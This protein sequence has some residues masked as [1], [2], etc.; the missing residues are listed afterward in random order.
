VTNQQNRGRR[1]LLLMALFFL[2]PLALAF[3]I[4]YGFD[5]RPAGSTVH[6]ELLKPP[7]KTPDIAIGP[8]RPGGAP[9][10]RR[11]WSLIVVMDDGCPDA[12]QAM[13]YETRQVRKALSRERD[14]TQ[15][16]LRISGEFDRATLELQHPDLLIVT[17]EMP[18]AVQLA[19]LWS[20]LDG[21]YIYLADP[22]G[23]V[24][25]RFPR[26]TGMKAIHTDLK[27]LLKLS[28]IG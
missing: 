27:K 5:W 16:V 21:N 4:Y 23:N 14:R 2:G 20:S 8:E 6:G 17:D 11:K 10:F 13:L 18:A 1:Q 12:C 25:M 9:A 7:I 24:M 15:R 22:L 3:V 26:D 28:R 19:Q